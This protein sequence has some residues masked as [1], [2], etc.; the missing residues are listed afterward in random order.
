M[1]ESH[2]RCLT[3]RQ[4][5]ELRCCIRV[6]VRVRVAVRGLELR[7]CIRVRVGLGVR[8]RVRVRVLELRCCIRFGEFTCEAMT[9]VALLPSTAAESEKEGLCMGLRSVSLGLG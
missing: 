7:C 6:R 9:S 5:R 4:G 8:V 1:V 3:G 2:G